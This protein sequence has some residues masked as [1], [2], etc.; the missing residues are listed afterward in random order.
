MDFF[1]PYPNDDLFF[2][3]IYLKKDFTVFAWI[4]SEN[5]LMIQ[6]YKLSYL[7]GGQLVNQIS[8][9]EINFNYIDEILSD[10]VKINDRKLAFI[11]TNSFISFRM[12]TRRRNLQ[13]FSLLNILNILIIDIQPNYIEFSEPKIYNAIIEDYIPTYQISGFVYNDFLLFTSTAI[14]IEEYFNLEDEINYLS[15]FMIF[16]YPNGTDSIIDISPFLHL[17]EGSIGEISFYDFLELNLTI[18]NNIFYYESAGIIKLVSIP[19]ELIIVE[20]NGNEDGSDLIL[21][22]NSEIYVSSN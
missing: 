22:N 15:M 19:D 20:K 1:D 16:G 21:Q 12:T 3:T 18:E 6:L 4:S 5:S 17:D 10:F 13:G 2:K 7:S 8:N 9:I 11:C 14:R